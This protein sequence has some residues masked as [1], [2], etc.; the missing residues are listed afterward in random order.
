MPQ[1]APARTQPTLPQSVMH[2]LHW[3]SQCSISL[4]ACLLFCLSIC[5]SVCL[6][7]CLPACL[8][9]CLSACLPIFL[10][11]CF[12]TCACLPSCLSVCV[13]ILMIMSQIQCCF[14]LQTYFQLFLPFFQQS[15]L[16]LFCTIILTKNKSI[17]A[18]CRS[19]TLSA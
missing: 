3:Q 9:V 6:P 12:P 5:L 10:S 14:S 7:V 1:Q 11:V 16:H 2:P 8:P 13:C 17:T 18:V 15:Y 19:G 4:P